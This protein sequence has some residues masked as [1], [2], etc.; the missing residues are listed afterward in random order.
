MSSKE[1]MMT[2]LKHTHIHSPVHATMSRYMTLLF[3]IACGMAVANIYFAHPLL[4][5]LS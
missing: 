2:T 1:K 4:D 5:S 3:A